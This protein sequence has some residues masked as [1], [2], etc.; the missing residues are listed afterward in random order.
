MS[1]FLNLYQNR[2]EGLETISDSIFP[3]NP[4]W[5]QLIIVIM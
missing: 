5:S 3:G 2:C 1:E 4:L